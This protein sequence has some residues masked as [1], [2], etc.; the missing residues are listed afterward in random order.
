MIFVNVG[1]FCTIADGIF[2]APSALQFGSN[3]ERLSMN[4]RRIYRSSWTILICA[5]LALS[6]LPRSA[7]ATEETYSTLQI[8]SRIYRNVTVTTKAKK[9]IFIFH[10]TGMENIRLADLSEELRSELGYVPELTKKEKAAAWAKGKLAELHIEVTAADL[11]DP[12]KMREVSVILFEKAR[13]VD[14]KL[15]GAIMGGTLFIF[16]FLSYCCLLICQKAGHEPSALIWIPILQI[17]PLL[18]AARMSPMWFFTYL[19][20]VPGLITHMVW[21]FRIA[22]ARRKSPVT[23]FLMLIPVLGFLPFFY[24]AFADKVPVPRVIEDRRTEHLM[25]LETA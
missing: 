21:C 6:I 5:V 10:S 1:I 17:F 9:Y 14:R 7:V 22:I 15:C 12:K 11:Q 23:G 4:E 18:R 13:V 25:T 16:F 24:L 20:I 2:F 8:G 19:L 3:P